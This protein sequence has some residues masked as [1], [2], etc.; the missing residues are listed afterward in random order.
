MQLGDIDLRLLRVFLAV[1]D[2]NGISNAQALLGRDA[3][4]ISKHIGQLESRLGF[5]L[6]ERGRSG[7]ALTEEGATIYRRATELFNATRRFE[8]DAL[9]MQRQLSGPIRIAMIDNLI[10][11]AACPLMPTLQR[12]SRREQND[13]EFF[14]DISAPAKIE[15]AVLDNQADIGIGIFMHGLQELEYLPLYEERDYLY[16]ASG[17]RLA[18]LVGEQLQQ[19]L[20]QERKVAREFLE[21]ADLLLMGEQSEVPHAW[22]SNIEAAAMLILA[23]SHVGFLPGHFASRWVERGELVALDPQQFQRVSSIQAITR[24]NKRRPRPVLQAFLDDLQQT[25]VT[26]N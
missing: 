10:T 18:G 2:A 12:F 13:V 8:Q 19:A 6:C 16:V 15:Q 24:K 9:A 11:D 5:R 7:F 17:H 25:C 23:G 1:A 26:C 4:T 21:Q 3:S 14:I 20:I 22:V